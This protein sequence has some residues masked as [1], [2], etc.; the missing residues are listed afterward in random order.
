[1]KTKKAKD[2]NSIEAEARMEIDIDKIRREKPMSEL[3]SFSIVNI[4]KPSTR[5]GLFS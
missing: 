1:M 2:E 4:D 3:M 5:F